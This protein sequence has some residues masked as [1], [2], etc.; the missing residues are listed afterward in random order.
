M[1]QFE[2]QANGKERIHATEAAPC[3][4]AAY[5]E[6]PSQG[7]YL[8]FS[9]GKVLGEVLPH[10]DLRKGDFVLTH[11]SLLGN[12]ALLTKDDV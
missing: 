9:L 11:P 5:V 2:V 12:R 8:S 10:M 7:Q 3:G 6:W 4:C 1:C